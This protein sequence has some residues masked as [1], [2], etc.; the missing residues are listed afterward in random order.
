M[1]LL[2]VNSKGQAWRKHSYSAGMTF[3]QSPYKYYLQKVLG[4]KEKE[5]KARFA[6]GKAFEN[7]IQWYHEHNGEGAVERFRQEWEIYKENKLL[8]Y[9][10]VEKDW[11][12][13]LKIGV[14][15]AKLYAIRQPSLP[16]PLSG[17]T[18]FQREFSKE[19]FPGDSNYGE[20]EYA[21]KL[22]II[23]Y[24]EPDH[25]MLPKLIWKPEYGAFRPL[26]IDIKTSGVDFPEAYGLAAYDAQLRCYSYLSGIRD[27]ALLWFVKKSPSLQKGYSVT[28]LEPAGNFKAG[29]EAVV[30]QIDGDNVIL[31]ANDFLIEEMEKAQGKKPDGKTDQTNAAKARRD[32]WLK[33]FGVRVPTTAITK[34]R[35]QFN[36]GYV[37]VDS[38][39]EAGQNAAR[40]IIDIVNAWHQKTAGNPHAY[41]NTFGVRFP[42]DDRM[43]PYFRAFVLGEEAVK[44]ENFVKTDEESLDDLFSDVESEA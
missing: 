42:R 36:A 21:G 34:Q 2:Y 17:Q 24:V 6:L 3:D 22:D 1:G 10:A 7:S 43:D 25:P 31:V 37:T 44:N 20:I 15:W 41:P 32:E 13:C 28:L 19:V 11:E 12:N 8:Q 14:D 9:T 30:A 33:N 26:I 39:L 5:N 18:I 29:D 23:A 27:V 38:A 40:Q 4:W 16:I 35:L